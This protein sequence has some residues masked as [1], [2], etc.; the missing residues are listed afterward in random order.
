MSSSRESALLSSSAPSRSP[1]LRRRRFSVTK[2]IHLHTLNAGLIHFFTR[3]Y[4]S[5]LPGGRLVLEPQPYSTYAKSAR[6]SDELK[7]NHDKLKA[8]G[9]LKPEDGDFERVL[10][11]E[12]GFDRVEKR[13]ETGE[14][15]F[16]RQV[17]VYYKREGSWL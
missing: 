9:P 14:K 2:W 10:L 1:L 12:I 4:K 11:E 6:L 17:E 5:L 16:R 13:G 7:A 15:G 3:L 8:E